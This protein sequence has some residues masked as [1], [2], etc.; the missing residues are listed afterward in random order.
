MAPDGVNFP[1]DIVSPEDQVKYLEECLALQRPVKASYIYM[2]GNGVLK[3]G[4]KFPCQIL[5][6]SGKSNILL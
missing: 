4:G 6:V 2:D 3:D 1:K 5:A